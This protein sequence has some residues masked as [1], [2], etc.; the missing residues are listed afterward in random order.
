M[1]VSCESCWN[2]LKLVLLRCL[3]LL[4]SLEGLLRIIYASQKWY[5]SAHRDWSVLKPYIIY[6]LNSCRQNSC[7]FPWVFGT[8]FTNCVSLLS[9]R[10]HMQKSA[11]RPSKG[12]TF[13]FPKSHN[14]LEV[15][16]YSLGLF[17]ETSELPSCHSTAFLLSKR[18]GRKWIMIN[19]KQRKSVIQS[20]M[21][22]YYWRNEQLSN[23]WDYSDTV[24][25]QS[26]VSMVVNLT[27][28]S[29]R[30]TKIVLLWELFKMEKKK[31]YFRQE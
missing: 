26:K 15:F 20:I 7:F 22:S 25:L 23:I 17:I 19:I 28:F 27:Y 1:P 10:I 24:P 5:I 2:A 31:K 11:T 21:Y 9:C 13:H 8:G 18:E 14:F 29:V 6:Y 16:P 3:T 12:S 30:L 4:C